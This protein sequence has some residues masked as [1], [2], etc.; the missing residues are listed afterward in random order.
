MDINQQ[1]AEKRMQR[2]NFW[3]MFFVV[4]MFSLAIALS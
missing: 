4:I 1:L 2:R 3:G